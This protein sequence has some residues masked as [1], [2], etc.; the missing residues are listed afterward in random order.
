[1]KIFFIGLDLINPTGGGEISSITLLRELSKNHDVS[2]FSI[3]KSLDEEKLEQKNFPFEVIPHLVP[4][5]TRTNLIPSEARKVAREVSSWK[6]IK[7]LLTKRNFDLVITQNVSVI[8]LPPESSKTIA[9]VRDQE[10]A[11]ESFLPWHKRIY[12]KPFIAIRRRYLKRNDLIL[13]NSCFISNLISRFGID[14]KVV[15]PFIDLSSYVVEEELQPEYITFINPIPLKGL[16]VVLKLAEKM[17]DHG[18]L[19][20][21][22][23]SKDLKETTEKLP[24]VSIREWVDDMKTVYRR[25]R[26]AL[27]PT[28]RDEPFGR[29]PIEAG[30]NGIPTIASSLGGLPESVGEGG[31]LVDE[32]Q[33]VDAWIRAIKEVDDPEKYAELSEKA[34][35]NAARFD[36]AI[37]FEDFKRV[38]RESL[39]IEI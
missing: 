22:R 28:I 8:P 5:H 11:L 38:V 14:S 1:M 19:I 24:N 39:E 30:I 26:V 37:T 12:N 34:R 6:K 16:N 23:G 2:A 33:N 15:Y 4:S 27:V 32:V 18:F 31:I 35:K 25:T 36:F 21:G 3:V 9:F 10:F 29:I 13:A 7:T 20:V 17:P